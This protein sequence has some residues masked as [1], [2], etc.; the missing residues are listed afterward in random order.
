MIFSYVNGKLLAKNQQI[1]ELNNSN[2]DEVLSNYL[3]QYYFNNQAKPKYC[4]VN[5][6]SSELKSLTKTTAIQFSTPTR[7]RYK[8][9]SLEAVKNAKEFF[10]S[11]Y[12]IYQNKINRTQKIFWNIKTIIIFR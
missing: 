5:I 7:G 3:M 4:Y 11:N 10:K 6:K 8:T 12:L 9:I 1:A 2:I